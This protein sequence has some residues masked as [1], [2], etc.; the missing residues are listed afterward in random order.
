MASDCEIHFC[1]C[2][3]DFGS[4]WWKYLVYI[5][6]LLIS[7]SINQN[8]LITMLVTNTNIKTTGKIYF[9]HK[10]L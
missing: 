9:L 5:L 10:I 2:H 6:K 4:V 8:I 7:C 1:L 3:A